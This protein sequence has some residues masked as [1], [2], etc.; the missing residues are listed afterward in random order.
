M[1]KHE[2]RVLLKTEDPR[3]EIEH[4]LRLPGETQLR[5]IELAKKIWPGCPVIHADSIAQ[6]PGWRM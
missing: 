1:K 4:T 6:A 5:S 3:I 2:I